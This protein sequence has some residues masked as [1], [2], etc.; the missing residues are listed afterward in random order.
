MVGQRDGQ[1]QGKLHYN[2]DLAPTL[3]APSPQPPRGAEAITRYLARR[4]STD[5]VGG[6]HSAGAGRKRAATRSTPP[7]GPSAATNPD[8]ASSQR[9]RVGYG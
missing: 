5:R 9:A 4:E 2:V 7:R 6:G 1:A 3:S 8:V